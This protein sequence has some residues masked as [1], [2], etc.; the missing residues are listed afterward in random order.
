MRKKNKQKKKFYIGDIFRI[1]GLV[2]ALSV[3]LYPT[4]SNYLY[5]KNGAKVISLYDENAVQL[6]EIEKIKNWTRQGST[7]RSFW[8]TWIC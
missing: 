1:I 8:E 3:L 5:K 4:V 6:S 7:I 2:I